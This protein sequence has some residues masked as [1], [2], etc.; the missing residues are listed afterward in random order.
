MSALSLRVISA[1]FRQVT[2]TRT[3]RAHIDYFRPANALLLLHRVER[4]NDLVG[5]TLTSSGF[6]QNLEP[7]APKTDRLLMVLRF[8]QRVVDPGDISGDQGL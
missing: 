7:L 4:T 2:A 6:A 1:P 5:S 3:I 8:T